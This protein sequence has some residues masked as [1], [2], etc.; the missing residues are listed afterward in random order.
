MII[1]TQKNYIELSKDELY[2][3]IRFRISIF[4]IEQN[5]IYEDLDG[6]D[7][8]AV[9]F[10]GT[11]NEKIVAYGRAHIDPKPAFFVIRRICVHKDYRDKKLGIALMEKIMRYADTTSNLKSAELDAQYHLLRFYEKFGFGADGEPYDDG[12]VMHIKMVRLN[13]Q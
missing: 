4:M 6:L 10:I 2:S 13:S 12:G 1:W 5:S 7:Q 3:I 11:D 9:H 8:Y